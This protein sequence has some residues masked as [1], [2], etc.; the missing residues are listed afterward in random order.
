MWQSRGAH[1]ILGQDRPDTQARLQ[2]TGALGLGEAQR[3]VALPFHVLNFTSRL[4]SP[5]RPL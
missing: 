4:R 2:G 1:R 3:Q 5:E